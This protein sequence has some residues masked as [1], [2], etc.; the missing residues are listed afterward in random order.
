M[1]MKLFLLRHAEYNPDFSVAGDIDPGLSEDGRK[2]AE[3]LAE[4]LAGETYD[5]IFVSPKKRTRETILPLIG[6]LKNIEPTEN[7]FLVE[8]DS[9]E[10]TFGR[11][12]SFLDFLKKDFQSST[13]LACGH[14]ISLSCLALLAQGEPLERLGDTEPF[15]YGEVRIFGVK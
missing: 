6:R 7:N 2:H 9:L 1:K 12:R 10:E 5:C 14:Q 11:A 4:K 13:V 3:V 8:G 15:A